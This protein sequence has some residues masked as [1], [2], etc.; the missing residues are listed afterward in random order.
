M[1]QVMCFACS[2]VIQICWSLVIV[3]STWV[4]FLIIIKLNWKSYEFCNANQLHGQ[5]VTIAT[6]SCRKST[7][8]HRYKESNRSTVELKDI[9]MDGRKQDPKVKELTFKSKL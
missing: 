5:K 2:V 1:G 4:V 9:S 8:K 3:E 6:K 7:K